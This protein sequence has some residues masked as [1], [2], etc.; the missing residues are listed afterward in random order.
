MI[1]RRV[2][3]RVESFKRKTK[4]NAKADKENGKKKTGYFAHDAGKIAE[5]NGR[6]NRSG[7]EGL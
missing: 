6:C 2:G 7:D 4:Q 5:D 1:V 3:D